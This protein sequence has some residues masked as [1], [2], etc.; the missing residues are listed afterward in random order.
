MNQLLAPL[1][2]GPLFRSFKVELICLQKTVLLKL[3]LPYLLEFLVGNLLL[4]LSLPLHLFRLL[5]FSL[6]FIQL[7]LE[8]NLILFGFR[9]VPL[10]IVEY[11]L[12]LRCMLNSTSSLK[13]ST[14]FVQLSRN[15]I[16]YLSFLSML[17]I[18]LR[19][20]S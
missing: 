10:F 18:R 9:I 13:I 15:Q 17:F 8:H 16:V 7:V 4:S 11:L 12:V 3:H 1:F 14:L 2:E 5:M 20:L 19:F 6:L